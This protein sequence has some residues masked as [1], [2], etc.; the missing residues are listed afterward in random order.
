MLSAWR[1]L[2]ASLV[3]LG[4]G[5]PTSNGTWKEDL[6]LK[7]AAIDQ[8]SPGNLGV[9]VKR[10]DDASA[11]DYLSYDAER[12]WYLSSTTKLPVA[13]VLLQ[14]VE[15][16]KLS[17][18]QE[19][20]LQTSDYVDGSGNTIWLK[21]GT[22]LKVRTLL[23]GMLV[24]S[25]STA[26][27]ML[28]RIIGEEELNRHFKARVSPLSF[29]PSGFGRI[30][31]LLQVRRD[32]YG[33]FHP[34]ARDLTNMDFIELKKVEPQRRLNALASKLGV[35]RGELR[36]QTLAE[37][38]ENYYRS[39]D[40]TADLVS[41]GRMLERLENGNLLNVE[42]TRWLLE[43]MEKSVTGE[44][45]IKAGLAPGSHFAQKTGTQYDRICDVGIIR[46][47]GRVP[48]VIA[49]CVEKF[50]EPARAERALELL[51]RAVTRS[52]AIGR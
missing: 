23:E 30:T 42:H 40:N 35:S 52:G 19:L 17:L 10:L 5:T 50:E 1:S 11:T 29:G 32:V 20:I 49:A 2:A 14:I 38:Y 48:L 27:D 7:I 37:G 26:T 33:E 4:I 51:G 3:L 39:G 13:I 25:D 31:T 28:I 41:Y 44:N 18:D 45:R 15:D 22:R 46:D 34:K 21:P 43:L 24:Q 16:G 12:P 47:S 6:R 9:Y 8:E 36:L